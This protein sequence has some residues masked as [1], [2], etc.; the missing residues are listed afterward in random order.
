MIGADDADLYDL[1]LQVRAVASARELIADP[2][3]LFLRLELPVRLRGWL[4]RR[5]PSLR[6]RVFV[7]SPSEL[8][9]E[10]RLIAEICRE[11]T[12]TMPAHVEALLWEGAGP[13]NPEAQPFPPEITGAGGQGVIDD[14]IW[15]RL[16]GYDVYLGMLWRRM[17]TP[18][19]RWRSGT[20]AEFQECPPEW[21]DLGDDP[22]LHRYR[23]AVGPPV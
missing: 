22:E 7:S 10:R 17:G 19:G 6:I 13:R 4:G 20:E 23:A 15:S 21:W 2:L 1:A 11:L 16:G 14:Y 12:L 18:T 8:R 5:S 9:R 3:V